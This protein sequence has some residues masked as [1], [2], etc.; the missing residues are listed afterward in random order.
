MGRLLRGL[1]LV[2]RWT[3]IALGA[4]ILSWL[5]SGV[6]MVFVPRPTLSLAE[7][8]AGLPP[9]DASAVKVSALDAWK[10]TGRS[11]WPRSVRLN[12]SGG[13]PVYHFEDGESR[14]IS[15]RADD[16]TKIE[17][18][19]PLDPSDEAALRRILAP[20]AGKAAID[21]FVAVERDQWSVVANFD[22]LRPL[23]RAELDDGRHYYVST[24]SGEV[25]LDTARAERAWNWL[26]TF[27]HWLYFTELRQNFGLWRAV[28]LWL[29]AAATLAALSGFCLGVERLKI[30]KPYSGGRFTPYREK[31]KRLHHV[32]GLLGGVFLLSWLFSGWL[33]LSP[34]AWAKTARTSE[35]ER[36]WL[37]GGALDAEALRR[38]PPL[39]AKSREIAW[40]RFDA[41]PTALLFDTD[42]PDRA[43]FSAS[44]TRRTPPLTLDAIAARGKGLKPREKLVSADWLTGQ[45]A[46]YYSRNG[47][48]LVLPVV[49]LRFDDAEKSAYYI[50]P[51]TG[52]IV[53]KIDRGARVQRWLYRGLHRLDF[54]PFDRY[55]TARRVLVVLASLLGILMTLSGCVL[56]IK[57]IGRLGGK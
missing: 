3:G 46:Y 28:I 10:S 55:E 23:V 34:M 52:S 6:V 26:G 36:A 27:A 43:V 48:K 38:T 18:L 30:L 5:V 2:H 16:A 50:D 1:H 21:S 8:L 12:A 13:R 31:W 44:D 42:V 25:V 47:R 40:A 14:R 7:R 39:G 22:P 4:L 19:D 54:P 29:A 45:D 24:R 49:R 41:Q 33:S 17:A 57:R 32:S 9:I 20:Y 51:A 35:E 15:V 56:G 11:G 37:A 53:S